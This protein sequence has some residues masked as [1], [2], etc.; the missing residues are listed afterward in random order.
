MIVPAT[1]FVY[2]DV[3]VQVAGQSLTA[4]LVVLSVFGVLA[5]HLISM[6][7]LFAFGGA[8]LT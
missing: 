2:R 7:S 8:S 1:S 4:T 6:L 3:L 5:V